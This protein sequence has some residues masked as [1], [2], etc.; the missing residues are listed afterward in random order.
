MGLIAVAPALTGCLTHTRTVP[1][2]RLADVVLNAALDQ[3]LQ[4]VNIRFD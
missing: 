4:Q 1:R 3:L 2:T